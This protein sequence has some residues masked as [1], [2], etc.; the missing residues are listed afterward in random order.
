MSLAF[1]FFFLIGGGFS[2]CVGEVVVNTVSHVQ[3]QNVMFRYRITSVELLDYFD[4]NDGCVKKNKDGRQ[5][6]LEE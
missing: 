1:N 2:F 6:S 5:G 3:E 4:V